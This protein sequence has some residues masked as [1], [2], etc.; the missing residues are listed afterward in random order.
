MIRCWIKSC[1]LKMTALRFIHHAVVQ[2]GGTAGVLPE[3]ADSSHCAFRALHSWM[4]LWLLPAI[5]RC[6]CVWLCVHEQRSDIK[7]Q[8]TFFGS[9]VVA[10][11]RI[12]DAWFSLKQCI[13]P[14]HWCPSASCAA[15][16]FVTISIV[17]VRGSHECGFERTVALW[18]CTRLPRGHV[19]SGCKKSKNPLLTIS[20]PS[21]RSRCGNA[22]K[23]GYD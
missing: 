23:A 4:L 18:V 15:P 10:K 5:A 7:L 8:I 16:I 9:G 1:R 21:V 14:L 6:F 22:G 12:H 3:T 11:L 19:K 13:V 2:N 20:T 17:F